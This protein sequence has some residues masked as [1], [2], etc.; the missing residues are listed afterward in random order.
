MDG[1]LVVKEGALSRCSSKTCGAR[2]KRAFYHFVSRGAFDIRGLGPKIIDRFL[3]EGL[4][5]DIADIFTLR[6][7]DIEVLER[8][9]EKSAENIAAEISV[10]KAVSLSAL[11]L[12]AGY[13]TRRR[14]NG[15]AFGGSGDFRRWRV[16]GDF[17]RF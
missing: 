9:G 7:G 12:L 3:D 16:A 15:A 1:S 4:L 13:F 2:H 10:K 14:R 8:F 6:K 5:S 11:H 17:G